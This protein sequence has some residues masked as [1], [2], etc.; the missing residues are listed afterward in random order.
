MGKLKDMYLEVW[1]ERPHYSEISGEP[2]LG[3]NNPKWLWQF[4]HVLGKGAF[5][6][7]K[8]RKENIMLMLPE[9]HEKQETFPKF[10][11]RKE[12]LKSQYFKERNL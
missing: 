7:F 3:I 5:P 2:L 10:M 8:F 6:S 9:E 4:A 1:E 12:E 11:E